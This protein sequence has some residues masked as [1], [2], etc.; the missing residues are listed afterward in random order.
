VYRCTSTNSEAEPNS[1][2]SD[3]ALDCLFPSASDGVTDQYRQGVNNGW[4]DVYDWYIPDQY[5]E[6][7]G[8]A[9]GLYRPVVTFQIEP[10]FGQTKGSMWGSV[11]AGVAA[12]MNQT[13]V[14]PTR[15]TYEF[16]A[17]FSDFKLFRDGQLVTP[18]TPGRAITSR[19]VD[20]RLFSF[21]DEAFS[22]VYSY[23]P[24]VFL[25]GKEWRLEVYDAREPGKVHRVIPLNASSK[26][27]QQL[28]QDFD[29]LAK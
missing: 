4:S 12:G 9:S 11:L 25:T 2:Q 20:E 5:I 28:R 14:A 16:K 1:G 6:V 7:S 21:V 23:D 29:M 15:Q 17:E 3:N 27:I 19:S 8:V 18:I 26:L 22:G 10:D 13:P 24:E